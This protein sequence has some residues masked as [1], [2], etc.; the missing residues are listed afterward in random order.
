[1]KKI[2]IECNM[3]VAGDM[4]CGA[5]LDTLDSDKRNETVNKLNGLFSHIDISCKSE[6]KCGICG[7]KFNV[8]IEEE[9]H[10]H[11]SLDE[12]YGII[13]SL[14]ISDNVKENAKAVYKIIADAESNVHGMPVCDIHLHEVGAKDAIADTVSCCY[15]F[16]LIGAD[17]IIVSPVTTGYGEVKCAHG[18]LSVPAPAT[19]EIL[20][21]I[22]T[23]RGDTESELTTPTGAALIKYFADEIGDECNMVCE[24]IGYGMGTKNFER[25]NCVRVFI[26]NDE[27]EEVYELRTQVDDMTGE[28][29]GYALNKMLSLGANDAYTTA[30]Y[31]KKS[32]PAYMLTVICKADK[33]DFFTEQM[34]KHTT[35]L[36]IRAVKCERATLTREIIE[37]ESVKIKRSEGYGIKKEKAEFDDLARTADEKGISIFEAK[38]ELRKD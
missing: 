13:D 7:T 27:N 1:M 20:K 8:Q 18:I 15:L 19:A 4:L 12:I 28:E 3:G 38:K 10:S 6:S 11:N 16:E 22:K 17:K 30:I 26:S 2:Y 29:I 33:K 32:R 34:F 23:R 24:K 5:L 14:N 25:P 35:T 36:G 21:G 37:T 31:M 9:H